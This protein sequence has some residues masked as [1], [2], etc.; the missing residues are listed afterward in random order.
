MNNNSLQV[1]DKYGLLII[2]L[3]FGF[4]IGVAISSWHWFPEEVWWH[5][6]LVIIPQTMIN[7]F[8]LLFPIIV[9][10][11]FLIIRR[12]IFKRDI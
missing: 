3:A 6:P 4:L 12:K 7:Y 9:L 10:F 11:V 2:G 1:Y 5:N 8:S